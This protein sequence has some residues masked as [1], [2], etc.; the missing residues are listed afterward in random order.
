MRYFIRANQTETAKA[1]RVPGRPR[2]RHVLALLFGAFACIATSARAVDVTPPSSPSTNHLKVDNPVFSS[3]AYLSTYQEAQRTADN[4]WVFSN[5]IIRNLVGECQ[6]IRCI[7]GGSLPNRSAWPAEVGTWGPDGDYMPWE[8]HGLSFGPEDLSVNFQTQS[9]T[10][11]FGTEWFDDAISLKLD[12]YVTLVPVQVVVVVPKYEGEAY[13]VMSAVDEE[14]QWA[15]WEDRWGGPAISGSSPPSGCCPQVQGQW[16]TLTAPTRASQGLYRRVV[17]PGSVIDYVR[18]DDV[19][20]QCGVQFRM[21]D[22]VQVVQDERHVEFLDAG[23]GICEDSQRQ[24]LL[25]EIL[26]QARAQPHVDVYG[27]S[28]LGIR[29]QIPT[30]VFNYRSYNTTGHP[31]D[32]P[33]PADTLGVV[34]DNAILVGVGDNVGAPNSD[35]TLSH[36]LGHLFQLDH[37]DRGA[38]GSLDPNYCG[39]GQGS[40]GHSC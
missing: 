27:N 20:A 35:L 15:L 10:D 12:P 19:F 31:E 8:V 9:Y 33:A 28:L 1:M 17:A 7:Q 11:S 38:D 5:F 32:C 16:T 24:A 36:L 26:Q 18:P 37:P 21:V 23:L 3:E 34:G 22:Y 30:V 2:H 13:D 29:S 39:G 40:P 6:D 4:R 14:S 25:A